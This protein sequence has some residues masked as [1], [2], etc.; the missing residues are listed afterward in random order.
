MNQKEIWKP[1]VGFEGFYEINLQGTIRTIE[2]ITVFGNRKRI[3]KSII[4]KPSINPHGYYYVRLYK[5]D[6]QKNV[7][8]HRAL[9]EA[10]VP[11]TEDKPYIDHI[12][13]IKTDNRLENLRW[14]TSKENTHNPLTLKHIT[15]S[16]STEE[17]KEKQ[18]ATKNRIKSKSYNPKR[19]YQYSLEGAYIAEYSSQSEAVRAMGLNKRMVS[20]IKIA[21]DNNRKSAYGYM[22]TTV[23]KPISKYEHPH[24]KYKPV[25]QIDNQGNTIRKWKNVKEA[26]LAIGTWDSNLSRYIR[27]NN[28]HYKG[29]IFKY[30]E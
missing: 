8:V 9:M 24:G 7:L 26:A 2:R 10:F 12:N 18:K 4:R 1:V 19:I 5:G 30:I 29:M 3:V 16:C 11:N 27:Y 23:K 15:D 25:K 17:C 22:W 6:K 13:T 20:N 21:L 14:V 28:G